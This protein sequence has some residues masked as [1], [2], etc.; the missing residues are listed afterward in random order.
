MRIVTGFLAGLLAS[1][2]PTAAANAGPSCFADDLR[3]NWIFSGGWSV[4]YSN[5]NT[6]ILPL[7]CQLRLSR[8]G[9][10]RN[11]G[12]IPFGAGRQLAA[13]LTLHRDCSI[14]G[15]ITLFPNERDLPEPGQ[16]GTRRVSGWL[17]RGNGQVVLSISAPDGA[18]QEQSPPLI[19]YRRP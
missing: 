15:T 14:S 6:S 19:G 3:G 9:S 10:G 18:P 2:L 13:K 4:T 17:I 12:C 16:Y 1:S 11:G 8:S 5:N 7:S